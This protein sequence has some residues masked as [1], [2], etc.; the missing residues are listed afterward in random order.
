MCVWQA[1]FLVIP[2]QW[3]VHTYL[4]DCEFCT[5]AMTRVF[6]V[7]VCLVAELTKKYMFLYTFFFNFFYALWMSTRAVLALKKKII[8]ITIKQWT[9]TFYGLNNST[10]RF[11][12]FSPSSANTIVYS[13]RVSVFT[14]CALLLIIAREKL[15]LETSRVRIKLK[16]KCFIQI[17]LLTRMKTF[18]F[19]F[20]ISRDTLCA[21]FHSQLLFIGAGICTIHFIIPLIF[22]NSC[23]P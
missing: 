15:F 13:R 4:S 2:K 12:F 1:Y 18:R 8:I 17:E 21:R 6:I 10:F 22:N 19:A 14:V 7:I 11:K 20:L 9:P 5:R 23:S 16:W 3:I